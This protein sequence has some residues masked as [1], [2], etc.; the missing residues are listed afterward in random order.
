MEYIRNIYYGEKASENKLFTKWRIDHGKPPGDTYVLTLPQY[1]GGLLER[2]KL[3]GL[4]HK[5]YKRHPLT[6][7]GVARGYEEAVRL[8]ADI[9]REVYEK[10]GGFDVKGFLE[11]R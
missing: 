8:A 6:V 1:N 2:R 3:S 7:V 11:E 9:V 10:S 5:F 4:K